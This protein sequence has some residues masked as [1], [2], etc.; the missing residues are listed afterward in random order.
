MNLLIENARQ[1]VTCSNGKRKY[2]S[3]KEQSNIKLIENASIYIERGVI[4]WIG[5]R[6]PE[7]IIKRSV[8]RIN[9]KNKVV[10]PGFVDSHTHLVFAGDR[11]DEYSMRLDGKSYEEIAKAGGGIINTVKAVRESSKGKLKE[12]SLERIRKF[13]SFG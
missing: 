2:K 9:A 11:A 4:N 3:G 1:I 5:R 6:V 13:I 7:S 10:M 12:L 8:K